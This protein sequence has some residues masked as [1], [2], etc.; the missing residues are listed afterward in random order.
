MRV[1]LPLGHSF[2]Y[3]PCVVTLRNAEAFARWAR[4]GTAVWRWVDILAMAVRHGGLVGAAQADLTVA[5][6]E[7]EVLARRRVRRM[8]TRRCKLLPLRGTRVEMGEWQ[9]PAGP[10][11]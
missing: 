11:C 1:Q 7:R 9:G 6:L 10:L 4:A 3:M 2:T 5:G 8:Q